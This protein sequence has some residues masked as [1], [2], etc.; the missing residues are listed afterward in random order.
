MFEDDLKVM[1]D[2][3]VD[4]FKLIIFDKKVNTPNVGKRRNRAN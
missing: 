1:I 4:N 3:I 2:K